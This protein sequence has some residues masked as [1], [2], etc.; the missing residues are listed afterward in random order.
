LLSKTLLSNTDNIDLGVQRSMENVYGT[1]T[2]SVVRLGSDGKILQRVKT[3]SKMDDAILYAK[4]LL[5]INIKATYRIDTT[6]QS[7]IIKR[8]DVEPIFEHIHINN[9]SV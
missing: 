8:K 9:G 6:T 2:Y 7:L 4:N 3:L 5:I 1:T